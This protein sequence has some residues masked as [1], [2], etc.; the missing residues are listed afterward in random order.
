M[1]GWQP[2]SRAAAEAV[3]GCRGPLY[4]RYP[5][6]GP[7]IWFVPSQRVFLDSRQDQYPIALVQA[8]SRVE[9]RGDYRAIFD[10]WRINCAALPPTSPTVAALERDN[11]LVKF[12]DPAWVVL[13]RPAR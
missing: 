5:D 13:E 11:W 10:R 3:A 2:V 4:N 7:L 1:L 6:G 12:S 9:T 8:A